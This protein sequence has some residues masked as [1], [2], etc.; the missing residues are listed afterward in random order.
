MKRNITA[1]VLSCIM[2]ILFLQA[3]AQQTT[4]YKLADLLKKEQLLIRNRHATVSKD[5]RENTVYL[6]EA[7][8]EGLAWINAAQFS[9]GKIDIDLKGQDVLQKS[10]LGIAFHGLNDSTYDAVYFRPFNFRTTDSVRRIHAVQY[11]SHPT[12]TWKKL[13][14]KRNAQFEKALTPVPDPNE[15]FHATIEV[16]AED[17]YVYVNHASAPSLHVKKLNDR[18][19]GWIGLWVGDGS[20]GNFSNLTITKNK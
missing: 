10:F 13:R 19:D 14:E 11:I 8:D 18:K 4:Q 1:T 2:L 15:W 16:T 5:V 3:S 6:D 20:G 17:I 12:Y 9:T 7:D